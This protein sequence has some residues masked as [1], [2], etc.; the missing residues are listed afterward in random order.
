MKKLVFL[1]LLFVLVLAGCTQ[2]QSIS[3]DN[4]FS[5]EQWS[6]KDYLF[7]KKQ[8]CARYRSEVE[9]N[10]QKQID[11]QWS[12][13]IWQSFYLEEIFYS[14][15]KNSCVYAVTKTLTYQDD[16]KAWHLNQRYL[17][18]DVLTNELIWTSM[19]IMDSKWSEVKEMEF[20]EK[21]K[22]LKWE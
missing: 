9:N 22:E 21:I 10:E 7:L 2:E 17:I 6:S 1:S 19:I 12:T 16:N 20:K 11:E 15:I 3:D 5:Q 4:S 14:P 8:E 18:K 13:D